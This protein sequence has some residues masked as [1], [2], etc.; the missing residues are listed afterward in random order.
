MQGPRGVAE[1]LGDLRDREA[2]E[3]TGPEGL[4]LPVFGGGG[5]GKKGGWTYHQKYSYIHSATI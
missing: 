2:F 3:E 5:L 1:A 4:V